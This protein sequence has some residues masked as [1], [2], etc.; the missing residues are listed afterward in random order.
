MV[1]NDHWPECKRGAPARFLGSSY[2]LNDPTAPQLYP[3]HPEYAMESQATGK[4]KGKSS[5]KQ[6]LWQRHIKIFE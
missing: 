1:Y 3:D 6:E 4:R 2:A 5:G